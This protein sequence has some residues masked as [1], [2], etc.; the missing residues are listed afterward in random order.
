[1]LHNWKV[2]VTLS[3]PR[4]YTTS[5]LS[6]RISSLDMGDYYTCKSM[7]TKMAKTRCVALNVQASRYSL[8]LHQLVSILQGRKPRVISI[9]NVIL[10]LNVL[11][12]I[13]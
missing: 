1:M 10:F 6:G 12:K 3:L 7:I 2:F 11:Y 9:K 4:H 13:E 5:A 8:L